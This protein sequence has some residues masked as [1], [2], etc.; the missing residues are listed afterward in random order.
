M[1]ICAFTHCSNSTYS[2]TQWKKTLCPEHLIKQGECACPPPFVLY[3]FP[4][5]EQCPETRKEWIKAVN[6][7]DAKTKKNWQPSEDSRVCSVHFPEGKPTEAFPSPAINLSATGREKPPKRKRPPPKSRTPYHKNTK[8]RKKTK[9][10][11]TTALLMDHDYIYKCDCTN[12]CMCEGCVKKEK[13][14]QH[15]NFLL[16][17]Q[18]HKTV[19]ETK[20]TLPRISSVANKF[21]KTDG[22][23]K[24]YT[25]LQSKQAFEDLYQYLFKNAKKMTYWK[26]MKK[27][28]STKV[29]RK[30]RKSPNKSGPER[31]L[32]IKDELL[33][34]LVKL[35]HA[36]SNELLADIFNISVGVASQI[37]NTWI[38]FLAYEL[39]PLIYWPPKEMINKSFPNS[40]KTYQNLRCTIDC[41]EVFIDRP[42]DLEI[43]ALTWSDYKKHN[44]IKFLVG[45]APNGMI[46]FL[47][48]AWGGRASDQHITKTSGFIE[49]IE[50]GDLILADR[51]FTIKEDIMMKGAFLKIPPPSSGHEQMTGKDVQETKK[52]A[53]A[54]IHVERAIGRMKNFAIL[55][56][57]LPITLLP[58]ADDIIVVCA[59]ICNLLPPLVF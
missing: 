25:G 19:E 15:Q 36:S 8:R 54:R 58:V 7:K 41:T 3:P 1:R 5:E 44:T 17:L 45:I 35:R 12:S 52:I 20:K 34:T 38:K 29:P 10:D 28:I 39:R 59:C 40:L 48:K 13:I 24:T 43:Q 46:T 55:K 22:K 4:I 42:R 23:V 6:R 14:I 37:F 18:N 50:P 57:V 11:I 51:G 27:T 21:L 30:C 53:N 16:D 26:G 9:I 56:T 32:S 2:L 31:K 33:L 47:S 49:L